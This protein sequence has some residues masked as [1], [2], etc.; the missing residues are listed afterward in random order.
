ML[1]Q[2][3]NPVKFIAN[4]LGVN[5]K[6]TSPNMN[7]GEWDPTSINVFSSPQGALGSRPGYSAITSASIG[8]SVAWCGFTQ[9]SK[10]SSGTTDYFLGGGSDGKV[11]QFVGAAYTVLFTGLTTGV[12]KRFSFFQLNNK[13]AIMNG[14]NIPLIWGGTGSATTFA[15]S[16]T[17][18]FGLEWQRYPWMHST[19]DPRLMYYG[20]LD[21][22]DGAYTT[23]LNFDQDAQGVTGACKQGDDMIVG[24]LRSLF[25]V[26][27]R[28]S[29]PLFKIYKI[30]ATIGPINHFGM[31]EL[32]NGS[33]IFPAADFNFY[34]LNGDTLQTCGDNIQPY[35]K[36]GVNSRWN[37][38]VGGVLYERHQYWCS[39]TYT[40]GATANDRTLVMD[41][42]RPYQDKWG[43]IQYP[44]FIYSV[45]ANCFAEINLTG[46]AFLYHGGYVGKMYKD[47]TGTNDDGTAIGTYWR[48]KAF[49][50]GDLSLEKKFDNVE[51]SYESKGNW[52]LTMGFIIDNNA[53]TEKIISQSML[54]GID[55]NT[56]LWDAVLWD[57]FNWPTEANGYVRRDIMR[58]GK[59]IYPYFS[60]QTLDQSWN[61][62]SFILHSKALGRPARQ[63][64]ST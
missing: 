49:D 28:G 34:M 46:R 55:P 50:F 20:P 15:T 61:I 52:N 13:V 51:M 3:Y 41:Y 47:D 19:V 45:A 18:D 22:P 16:V 39:M 58:Q 26:Q 33:V 2:R 23:F 62:F 32:P 40:S 5:A 35:V 14:A 4:F 38:C 59:T 63:R 43:K 60:Q 17:A 48:G 27:Y 44:W 36:A 31:K 54:S 30:P 24:K 57:G 29:S 10:Q 25:R 6:D 64:E 12:D 7:D 11:Y 56:A 42:E 37:L 9:Y 1:G 8:T 53:A 21:T